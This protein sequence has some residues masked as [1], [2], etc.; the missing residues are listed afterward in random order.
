M[1]LLERRRAH[2]RRR[3]DD[4]LTIT[5]N[6]RQ[7]PEAAV[8]ADI[9]S[10]SELSDSESE[11]GL[12]SPDSPDTPDIPAGA[13]AAAEPDSPSSPSPTSLTFSASAT[14]TT[15]TASAV[16]TT[17]SSQVVSTT[18][19]SSG[20]V[21][22][23]T[24]IPPESVRGQTT[25]FSTSTIPSST[26][27]QLLATALPLS[28]EE[29][30]SAISTTIT[31]AAATS[32]PAT[33][34]LGTNGAQVSEKDTPS[35]ESGAGVHIVL[36]VLAS[37]AVVAGFLF[38]L[39]KWKKRRTRENHDNDAR[40]PGQ[41]DGS[42]PRPP[43]FLAQTRPQS[44]PQTG[45]QAQNAHRSDES[46]M[47]ELMNAAYAAENGGY[48]GNSDYGANG[49]LVD[50]KSESQELQAPQPTAPR[51]RGSVSR[52]LSG[53]RTNAS[54][55][56]GSVM[57]FAPPARESSV[58]SNPSTAWPE[59]FEAADP[60][61]GP[62]Q[63]AKYISVWSESTSTKTSSADETAPPLPSRLQ[64]Y[65]GAETE[66]SRM[67]WLSR[68][69]SQQFLAQ[70]PGQQQS[71]V[72]MP[73]RPPSVAQTTVTDS[74]ANQTVQTESTWNTWGVMQHKPEENK[75]WLGKLKNVSGIP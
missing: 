16:I 27:D 57:T 21:L 48:R 22:T 73:V 28:T 36:P 54:S 68:P 71:P 19:T 39:W 13:L 32:D 15:S 50:E 65:Y 47:G 8:D 20:N 33:N 34:G 31:A 9:E 67:S 55:V 35:G 24:A 70:Q 61:F 43:T 17:S 30:Q 42:A 45:H 51:L 11:S 44:V 69:P 12:A 52:W 37:V 46:I 59:G 18:A 60:R 38:F 53:I 41:A 26:T 14:E 29:S 6:V 62:P 2:F 4:D 64:S 66:P 25:S 75:G 40:V 49:Y 58:P 72:T 1:G 23:L 5:V 56:R 10:D 3:L 63:N 7:L 74:T